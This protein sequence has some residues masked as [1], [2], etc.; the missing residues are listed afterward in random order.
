MK[1]LA[2]ALLTAGLAI[3]AAS[4]AHAIDFKMHGVWLFSVN[5]GQNG[6]FTDNGHAGYDSSEDEFEP[7]S[8]VRLWMDAVAS[9]ALSGQVYIEIGK[10]KWGKAGSTQQ[11]GAALGADDTCIKVKR[12]FLDWMVPETDFKVRMGIQGVRTPSAALDGPTVMQADA[13]AIT[14]SYRV[15]ENLDLTGMWTRP[16]NDNY[17]NTNG[18]DSNYMDN[19]DIGQIAADIHFDGY[20][21]LPWV[22]YGAIG[23]NTF[24]KGNNTLG[25]RIN[26]VDG[27]YLYSGMFPV[28]ANV[29]KTGKGKNIDSYA[30]CWWAGLAGDVTAFGPW[31]FAY[32]FIY[33]SVQW[34][35]DQ[36]LDRRGWLGAAVVEYKM[37]WG[38]PGLFGWYTSGDDDDLG[39]GSE[40]LP[41]VVNDFGMPTFGSTYAGPDQNGLERDRVI[42]N[43]LVGTWG[44]GFRLKN[45]SFFEN[46]KHT[47]MVSLWGGTNDPGIVDELEK[48]YGERMTPNNTY[49]AANAHMT[50]RENLYMTTRDY[51][52]EV[53]LRNSWKIYDN[54]TVNLDAAYIKLY[55]DTDDT[56]KHHNSGGLNDA[57]N[58]SLLFSYAF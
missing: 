28:W 35:D 43:T 15:N 53:S 31:R 44:V 36:S 21:F 39:N 41:Y 17:E 55:M 52:L 29:G 11:G 4:P 1:K 14:M 57:W 7:R 54:F 23:P 45:M 42:G 32:E 8:R 19:M 56:W 3:G 27:N 49:G 38:T 30:N 20:K 40:R 46:L 12:A 18:T 50:G 10:S 6:N 22:M 33:G 51:A 24:R 9:E 5:Y 2:I 34:D 26:G 16:Y 58:I 47:F 37:D 13:A 25:K 48:R